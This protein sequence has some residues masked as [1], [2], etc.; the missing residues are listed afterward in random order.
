MA[1]QLISGDA[2]HLIAA[3]STSSPCG[4]TE[5]RSDSPQTLQERFNQFNDSVV[6]RIDT[7]VFGTADQRQQAVDIFECDI[8][9]VVAK[10]AEE[11]KP[12]DPETL[13]KIRDAVAQLRIE[14][15]TEDARL[16]DWPAQKT[17]LRCVELVRAHTD[18]LGGRV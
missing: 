9:S 11:G 5:R 1:I 2:Q 13:A 7:L 4:E 18:E 16:T 6:D 10:A 15:Q 14:A 17:L 3:S 12:F 8:R